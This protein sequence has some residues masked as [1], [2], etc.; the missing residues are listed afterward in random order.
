MKGI[1]V[2]IVVVVVMLIGGWL[3]FS[4]SGD[5]ASVTV[6]TDKIKN[7]AQEAGRKGTEAMNRA[8]QETE[9]RTAPAKG[10]PQGVAVPP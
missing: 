10:H 1:L 8:A 6:H 5:N 2:L 7:D 4:S 9:N 3:T